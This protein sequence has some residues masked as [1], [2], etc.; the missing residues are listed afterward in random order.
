[1][2]INYKSILDGMIE[3]AKAASKII[4]TDFDKACLMPASERQVDN[5]ADKSSLPDFV[6]QTDRNAERAIE[7]ALQAR[8]PSIP[9]IG[10][11]NG[12]QIDTDAYYLVDPLDGTSNFIALRDYFA[13]SIAY[14]EGDEVKVAVIADPCRDFY[15][16]AI[17]GEGAWFNNE[18]RVYAD[19]DTPLERMQLE[20]EL[21][22]KGADDF[23]VVTDALKQMSGMR[24]SGSTALDMANL[25]IGRPIVLM[26]SNL[27]PYDLAAGL[28]IVCEAGAEV[29][30]MNTKEQANFG[31]QSIMAG[32]KSALGKI[33]SLKQ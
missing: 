31:S 14:I 26:A 29:L 7:D 17:A 15:V 20:C 1:M 32:S 28:L 4:K 13:V 16:C 33:E 22:F 2:T 24:K 23:G 9:V 30:D 19:T 11:E 10:E 18:R 3:A 6:T 8:S 27:M 25:V 21:V 5:K 12:R